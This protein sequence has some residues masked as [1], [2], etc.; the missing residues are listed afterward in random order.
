M[1][2]D[3][4]MYFCEHGIFHQTTYV[5]TPQQNVIVEWKN[6]HLIEVTRSLMLDKLVPKSYW[7]DALLTTTYLINRMPSQVLDFK[8]LLELLSPPFSTSKGASP[9]V[10]RCVC[11]VHVHVHGLARG[12]LDPRALKCVFV[13]Y[14]LMQK[15]CKCYHPPSRKQFV[16]ST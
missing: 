6:W 3:L 5:D 7:E 16:S 11:F 10:F 15:G 1:S 12:K 2:S 13:G 14:S 9:K 8:T 4:R